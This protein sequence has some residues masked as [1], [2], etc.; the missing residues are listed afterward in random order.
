MMKEE[1]G[2][3]ETLSA[4]EEKLRRS[5]MDRDWTSLDGTLLEVKTVS[6]KVS[7]TE[8]IRATVYQKIRNSCQAKP[9]EGFQEILARVPGD[10]RETLSALHR[11]VRVAVEKV[12]CL[13]GGLDTYINSAVSTMDKILDELLP[14]RKNKIYTRRGE[15]VGSSRPMMISQSL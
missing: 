13:T 14:E 6:E 10:E 11:R 4:L 2:A 15:A 9:G 3:L 12:K 5:V 1:A 7:Q 8:Q